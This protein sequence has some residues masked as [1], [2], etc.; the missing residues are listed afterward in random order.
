VKYRKNS[1]EELQLQSART[2]LTRLVYTC[3]A[4]TDGCKQL[5]TRAVNCLLMSDHSILIF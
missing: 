3:A 5:L 2:W 4:A 1:A